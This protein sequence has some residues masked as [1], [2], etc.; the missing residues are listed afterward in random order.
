MG[1]S[2]ELTTPL[3][4]LLSDLIEPISRMEENS[5]EAQSTEEILWKI[6]D[7]NQRLRSEGV[8]DIALG[9]MDFIA[10]YPSLDQTKSAEIV[11]EALVGSEVKY[12]GVDLDIA[13][14]YLANVWDKNRLKKEGIYQ[15]MPR[16]KA[17]KGRKATINS[18]ELSGHIPREG[19]TIR[20]NDFG[21][22]LDEEEFMVEENVG[23][24]W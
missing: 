13:G 6:S 2:K 16:K 5:D 23:S 24:K 20:M 1:A 18:K 3:G 17:N 14:V 11:A 7:A 12:S 9:S 4:E 10:L 21:K 8:S 22:K 19:N 15:L